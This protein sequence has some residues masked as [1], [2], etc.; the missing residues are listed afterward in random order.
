MEVDANGVTVLDNATGVLEG[1]GLDGEYEGGFIYSTAGHILDPQPRTIVAIL[2]DINPAGSLVEATPGANYYLTGSSPSSGGQRRW[3]LKAFD[4]VSGALTNDWDLP[5]V[6]GA[7]H[8]LVHLG[9]S[10][11]A[12]ADATRIVLI[13][14]ALF[15]QGGPVVTIT[16]PTDAPSIA[17]ES[18][19]VTLAGT[20]SDPDGSIAGVTWSTSRGYSGVASGTTQWFA[21]DIS[22]LPGSNVVTVT[23]TDDDG[24]TRQATLDITVSAYTSLLAEG[25]TGAFFDYDLLLANPTGS[26]ITAAVTFF[27]EAGGSVVQQVPL[28]AQSRRTIRVDDIAGLES[29]TMSTS[30]RTIGAPILVERTMRWGQAGAPSTAR[31]PTRPRPAPRGPGISRRAHRASSSRT[32]CSPIPPTAATRRPSTG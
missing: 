30:V 29:T 25:A 13:S 15:P 10:A 32:C 1:A 5:A 6:D 23:A 18:P 8:G 14:P 17:I 20:A 19:I 28:P 16:S 3:H 9:G 24:R 7:P 12:F 4:R 21:S 11:L 22:L 26:T 27:K 2:P 31:T